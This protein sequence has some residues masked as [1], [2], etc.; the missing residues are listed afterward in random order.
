QP[1]LSTFPMRDTW[2]IS[3]DGRTVVGQDG[4]PPTKW[5]ASTGIQILAAQ[6]IG[7]AF[8]A[9]ADAS[10]IVGDL[11]DR[12]FRW[13]QAT[14]LVLLP[15]AGGGGFTGAFGISAD[16][17]VIAGTT[18]GA[19]ALFATIWDNGVQQII[20]TPWPG[21][22]ELRAISA[23]GKVV[24]GNTRSNG[25]LWSAAAGI[26]EIPRLPQ[27]PGSSP[28]AVLPGGLNADGTIVAGARESTPL[29]GW[30]LFRWTP[31]QPVENIPN[32]AGF[33]SCFVRGVSYDGKTIVGY[34]LTQL[35]M[36]R[37]F[38]WKEGRGTML[39]TD[40]LTELGVA[41]PP[42]TVLYNAY[43]V[44]ASGLVIAG[45]GNRPGMDFSYR[46]ELPCPAN[47]DGS[48]APPVL[49]VSD[50]ICFLNKFA[51]G[52][53]SANCDASTTPPTLNIADFVCFQTRFAAGCP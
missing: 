9:S 46:V 30:M 48:T 24:A 22:S 17:K 31:G 45:E 39:L 11:D 34:G 18:G 23:D 20:T 2:G 50:F 33:F 47:C 12:P 29:G 52:Q 14:G 1:G 44:S 49:N 21:N 53:S 13:T 26:V 36:Y 51:A 25:F 5:S 7:A 38:I 8:A 41:M 15:G 43:G 28:G 10:I 4:Q 32:L 6:G 40:Y 19:L 16:G 3:P 35:G 27:Q 42:G 37:A